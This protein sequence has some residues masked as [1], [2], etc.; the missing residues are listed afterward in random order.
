MEK[1][2]TK[3]RKIILFLFPFL[4]GIT[5]AFIF[6]QP[7][8]KR[9]KGNLTKLEQV[10]QYIDH[11]YMDTVN[12]DKLMEAAI[13]GMLQSLDPH[14]TYANA[15]D[16]KILQ[17]QLNGSFDGIG[18]QF[19]IINDTVTVVAVI[20]GG[21]AD[22]VGIFTGDRIVL[23]DEEH[24]AGVGISNED[25]LNRLRGAKNSKV[26]LGILRQGVP[27]V[28]HFELI[29]D[30]I[31][32]YTVDTYYMVQNDIGYI[33]ID[34]FGATTADEFSRALFKLINLGM[35]KLILDLRGNSGGY[36]D[37]AIAVC[38]ELLPADDLIVYTEG[39]HAKSQS[40]LATK[41]GQFEKG[42]LV[43]L[44]DDF[45]ASASEVVAG[46]VQD[47]DRGWIVGRRS[48]GKGLVQ[49]QFEL[50]DH[51][52]IRLTTSRY[53]TPSGRSIQKQYINGVEAYSEEVLNRFQNGE[54]DSTANVK[55]DE[56][57]KHFTKKGR[58]VYGGGGIMPDYFVPIGRDSTLIPFNMIANSSVFTQFAF[59]YTTKN[60]KNL[61][62]I[63]ATPEDFIKKMFVEESLCNELVKAYN[64]KNGA[65]PV[66]LNETSKKELKL[67][68]KAFV[69]K[70]LYQNKAF[71]QIINSS[72]K[73]VLKA[74]SVIKGE[75]VIEKNNNKNN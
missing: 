5:V 72:D 27:T 48:F 39:L 70:N 15:V 49:Q 1:S 56:K 62:S 17:E 60:S 53:H 68:L 67:W 51:S 37:A 41:Y 36:L 2:G 50:V 58:V 19:S 20:S 7:A 61:K 55:F 13:T 12:N 8:N 29:R 31:P 30:K 73:T 16:N 28:N 43:V 26:K 25:V 22:K 32:T 38:D 59:D 3:F 6:I 66:V 24:F 71:Y 75:N 4:L 57:L 63:Y 18:V 40:Y 9:T 47:N 74:I 54:M 34:Q 69:G 52:N 14:S 11:Y 23:V 45:S 64:V 33:R 42:T 46:A 10:L 44:I 35:Q 65:H 21:P